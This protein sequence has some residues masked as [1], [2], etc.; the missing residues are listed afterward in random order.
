MALHEQIQ[1]QRSANVSPL[2]RLVGA[3]WVAAAVGIGYFLAARL[4]LLLLAKPDGVAV[5]WPAAGISS[6]ILI[7]FGREVR[8]PVAVGTIAA[9]IVANLTSD[10]TIWSA[11]VFAL[12]NAGEALLVA[13][14][15]ERFFGAEFNLGRLRQVLGL[16]VAAIIGTAA[17]GIPATAAYRLLHSPDASVFITWQH[18]FASDAIGIITIAPSI[19]GLASALRAPPS[20]RELVEGAAGLASLA[21]VLAIIIFLPPASWGIEVPVELLFPVLLW[22]TARCGPVFTAAAVFGVS[23]AFVCS[24]TFQ[25]GL[26]S[27][28]LPLTNEHILGVQGDILGVAIFAYILAALFEERRQREAAV[29]KNEARLQNALVAGG[30]AAFDWDMQSDLMQNSESAAEILGIDP[31]SPVTATS[32]LARIHPDDRKTLKPL[33][34]GVGPSNPSYSATFRYTRPDGREVWLEEKSQVEYDAAGH[35]VRLEGVILDITERKRADEHQKMLITELDHRVKNILARV[36]VVAIQTREGS[37]SIDQFVKTL[38]GR[39]QSMAAAHSLL[40]QASWNG[41]GLTDLVRDQL[42]PYMG[43][44]NVNISGPNVILNSAATQS[45]AMT[46]HELVTNAAKHGALSRP[47]GQVLVSWERLVGIGAAAKLT[48]EWREVGGPIVG[49]PPQSGF[50]TNLIRDLIPHELSGTVDLMFG[51]DGICCRIEVPLD[52]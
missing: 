6:G 28:V 23:L 43:Q 26:F 7:A 33:A 34:I 27:N 46:L 50:G 44:A 11:S 22:L 51:S 3:I 12:C 14:L 31:Q 5:F 29:M 38:D 36:A 21:V 4:S 2:G 9:T 20:R 19:I 15:I 35:A 45:I 49:A 40:S 32:F 48:L 41:V 8:W 30:V 13:W 1:E 25:L 17:S 39:I 24:V 52:H 16:L 37:G 18:W 10:R 42:A 47:S